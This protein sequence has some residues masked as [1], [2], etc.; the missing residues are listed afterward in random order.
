MNNILWID[1]WTD[2]RIDIYIYILVM[3]QNLLVI[4]V[5]FSQKELFKNGLNFDQNNSYSR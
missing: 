1:G 4:A 3:S 2:G 5:D